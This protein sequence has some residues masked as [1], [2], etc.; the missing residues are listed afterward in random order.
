MA[1]GGREAGDSGRRTREPGREEG[2][3]AERRDGEGRGFGGGDLL[4]S[5]WLVTGLSIATA[6]A[7]VC[8]CA[9]VWCVCARGGGGCSWGSP[10]EL[11]GD[12]GIPSRTGGPASA[13]LG[14]P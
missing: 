8:V 3:T 9:R 6:C 5:A 14:A 13:V 2:K 12:R 4:P 1:L 11:G 10:R 7:R